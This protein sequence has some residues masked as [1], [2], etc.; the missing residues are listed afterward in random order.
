MP[1]NHR[2]KYTVIKKLGE[3]GYGSVYL[4]KAADGEELAVK[5]LEVKEKGFPSLIEAYIMSAISHPNLVHAIEIVAEQDKCFIYQ[6]LAKCDLGHFCRK[7]RN[8]PSPSTLREWSFSLVQAIACLHQQGIV[9]GDVKGSNVLLFN[10]DIKLTDFGLSQKI[11]DE[12]P[13]FRCC[14][15]TH[16]PLEIWLGKE[17]DFSIDIW[18]LGCTLY[19]IAYGEYLIPY[20]GKDGDTKMMIKE[21]FIAALEEF[22]KMTSQKIPYF[23]TKKRVRFYPPYFRHNPEYSAFNDLI[24]SLVRMDPYE[25]PT[26]FEIL[27]HPFFQSSKPV[28]Y[29]VI[30]GNEYSLKHEKKIIETIK[31]FTSHPTIIQVTLTILRKA[32]GLHL[33][34]NGYH[35]QK[36]LLILGAYWIAC[37]LVLRRIPEL[38]YSHDLLFRVE[39]K[40]SE[41]LTFRFL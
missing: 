36:D 29:Q 19:E 10:N 21:R 23:Y 11:W 15:S 33:E 6:P 22:A 4:T 20:Q 7:K 2:A 17:W 18:S 1:L 31:K 5:E 3:G 41:F 38:S 26:I 14:T 9:H 30:R 37:K 25:R 40:I 39:F 24:F 12:K 8:L 27:R 35:N 16:R 28:T 34:I 32:Q 13:S